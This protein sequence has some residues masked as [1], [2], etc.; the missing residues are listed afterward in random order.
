MFKLPQQ[1][2]QLKQGQVF[3]GPW[4][5]W[6]RGGFCDA[7]PTVV[8]KVLEGLTKFNSLNKALLGSTAGWQGWALFW[9]N[10]CLFCMDLDL[11]FAKLN[12]PFRCTQI[13]FFLICVEKIVLA[14]C[15]CGARCQPQKPIFPASPGAPFFQAEFYLFVVRFEGGLHETYEFEFNQ[16]DTCGRDLCAALGFL[17][18]GLESVQGCGWCLWT[19]SVSIDDVLGPP[20]L[21]PKRVVP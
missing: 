15:W 1:S 14:L 2:K 13:C 12:P 11:V 3:N 8:Q 6:L 17:G 9:K 5:L 18:V 7:R 10:R 19:S 20:D 4:K 21:H 16:L